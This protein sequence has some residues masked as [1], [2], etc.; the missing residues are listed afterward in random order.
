MPPGAQDFGLARTLGFKNGGALLA[1]GLH[2]PAHRFHDV[3][4]R[5]DVLDLDA[6]DLHAPGRGRRIDHRQQPLVD[7]VSVRQKL[8]E[9]HRP[10]HGADVG[11]DDVE[12]RRA[13]LGDLVRG[14][15]RVDDLEEGHAIDLHRGI[16]LGD[17][18]LGRHVEHL[19]HHVHLVPDGIEIGNDE[20]KPGLERESVAAEA[21]DGVIIPLRDGADAGKQGEHGEHHDDDHQNSETADRHRSLPDLVND[22]RERGLNRRPGQYG[23]QDE[24]VGSVKAVHREKEDADRALSADGVRLKGDGD[25]NYRP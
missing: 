13:E 16:V 15:R 19:L 12:E 18:L 3:G 1:L 10:H 22:S 6:V 4:R 14:A 25:A 20:A 9:I 7:G 8:V 23:C 17:H 2:L 11:G 5:H 24:T 21:F